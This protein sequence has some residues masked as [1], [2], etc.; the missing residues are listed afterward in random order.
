MNSPRWRMVAAAAILALA[1]AAC[2]GQS[3]T[4]TWPSPPTPTAAPTATP[5]PTPSPT[6]TVPPTATPTPAPPTPTPTPAPAAT[7]TPTPTATPTATATPTPTLTPTP[8][9]PSGLREARLTVGDAT[10]VVEIADTREAR[11]RGLGGRDSLDADRGMW[12]VFEQPQWA[13]FWMR[14]VRFPLDIVWVTDELVVSGVAP[15]VPPPAPGTPNSEL[16]IY[17]SNVQVRYVLEIN[18]GLAALHG[19]VPGAEVSVGDL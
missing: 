13:T 9:P 11:N 14:G 1:C 17:N 7:A 12:F 19:I 16:T 4:P 10:F 8:T 2:V 18:A 5:T 3:S 15:N 6:P